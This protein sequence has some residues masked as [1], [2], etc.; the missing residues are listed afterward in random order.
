MSS[1]FTSPVS[2]F[3]CLKVP[4]FSED[5][6]RLKEIHSSRHSNTYFA[7]E[8]NLSELLLHMLDSNTI[9]MHMKYY[10]SKTNVY[11]ILQ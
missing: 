11:Y 10:V 1:L 2:S 6:R 3:I 5:S 4:E 9:E 7:E 8:I